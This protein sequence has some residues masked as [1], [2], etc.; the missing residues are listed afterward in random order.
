[1]KGTP[2]FSVHEFWKH[3]LGVAIASELLAKDTGFGKPEEA[4]TCGLLHDLGKIVLYMIHK[5]TLL[6][7]VK[8][9]K[10]NDI[11]FSDAEKLLDVRAHTYFGEVIA[12]KWGLPMIIQN[13]IHYHHSDVT[14]LNTVVPSHKPVI[15]LVSVADAL[16]KHLGIGDSGDNKNDPVDEKLLLKAGIDHEVINQ[17]K[18]RLYNEMEKAEGY[19]RYAA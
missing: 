10:D 5:P 9:A 8:T 2:D 14:D 16:V 11:T 19:L 18:G 4:F 15:Q 1:V 12:S 3:A 13:T 17:V 6:E 7:V